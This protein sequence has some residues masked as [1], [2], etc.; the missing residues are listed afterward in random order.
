VRGNVAR[1]IAA[2]R[3]FPPVDTGA[4]R[5]AFEVERVANGARVE[6]RVPYAA[7]IEIGRLPG[8]VPLAPILAWVKRKRLYEAELRRRGGVVRGRG[9]AEAIDAAALR[10]AMAIRRKLQEHGMAPRW[11]LRRALARSRAEVELAIR[12]ALEGVRP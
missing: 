8:P 7:A 9:R 2:V 11:V 6:N 1:A 12:A 5:A 3:P 4:Y 10:V